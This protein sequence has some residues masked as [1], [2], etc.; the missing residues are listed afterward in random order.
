[1][2]NVLLLATATARFAAAEQTDAPRAYKG[3]M[4]LELTMMVRLVRQR[5]IQAA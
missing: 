5:V 2:G 4:A 3:S 1:M